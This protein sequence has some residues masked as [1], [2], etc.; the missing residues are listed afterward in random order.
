MEVVKALLLLVVGFI[1]LVKGADFFVEGAASLAKKL[2]VPALIIGMTVVAMG[3]SLPELAVS[4]TASFNNSNS[5]AISNVV[6]SNI[7]NLMVV[8][9]AS[10]LFTPILVAKDT[11]KRDFPFSIIC[12]LLLLVLGLFGWNFAMFNS[13]H[14]FICDRFHNHYSCRI[15]RKNN[16][17]FKRIIPCI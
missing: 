4:V 9:G 7:F 12:A 16:P 8:L 6:G 5:L 2:R 1:L 11:L 15:I 13:Y 14:I 10:A 3:T 17:L